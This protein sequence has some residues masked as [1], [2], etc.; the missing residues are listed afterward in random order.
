M[1]TKTKTRRA[2]P[3]TAT[4]KFEAKLKDSCCETSTPSAAMPKRATEPQHGSVVHVEFTTP[5][6][7]KGA[8]VYSAV[9]G[10]QFFPFLEGELYFTTPGNWGPCGCVSRGTPETLGR[11]TL[12]VNVKDIETTI[13][14]AQSVGAQ[15]HKPKTEIP[16]GHGYIALL[17]MPDGN[18]FGLYNA[19]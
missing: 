19:H 14:K 1:P 2:S 18:I 17:R 5:D 15:V 10:W 12:Y 7:K 4:C 11:T 8:E 3:K 6:L 9:F 13:K 16:G